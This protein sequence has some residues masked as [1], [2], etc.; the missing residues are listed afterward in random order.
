M[1]RA[2]KSVPVNSWSKV[3]LTSILEVIHQM[4]VTIQQDN[5]WSIYN[6]DWASLSRRS[7][8]MLVIGEPPNATYIMLG[9]WSSQ[10]IKDKWI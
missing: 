1:I 4:V 10:N 8:R 6:I 2:I 9:W 3:L 5:I 7:S